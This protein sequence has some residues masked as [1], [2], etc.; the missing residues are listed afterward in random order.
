[1]RSRHAGF[2]VAAV[3]VLVGTSC[4][5][6]GAPQGG[7]PDTTA[8]QVESTL[9]A[10]GDVQVDRLSGLTIQFSEPIDKATFARNW[11]ISPARAG[12]AKIKWTNGGRRVSISW[13]D[14][15]RDS[16]SY[17]VTVSNRVADRHANPLAEP[18]TFAFSTGPQVDRGEIRGR[19][20]AP[21]EGK[22][23]FDVFAYR[24]E[25]L[26][27][28]FWLSPPDY[29]TQSAVDGRFQLPFLRAG[30]YRLLVLGDNNRNRRL[31]HNESFALAPR[32]F[33]VA[34]DAPPDSA[35]FFVT[36][37]DT[38]PFHLRDCAPVGPRL[39]AVGFS[40]PLDTAG[41]STWS[42][43]VVDS[44]DGTA[45]VATMLPP[46]A[47]RPSQILLRGQW[48]DGGV[49]AI[50]VGGM[51]DQR[52]QILADSVCRCVYTL[53]RDSTGPRIEMVVLPEP[54]TALTPRDPIRWVF[55]EP[56]DTTQWHDGVL[57][58]DT[59]GQRLDGLTHWVH[60]Q[61]LQ[62]VPSAP[63]P[64]TLIALVTL[65]S[66]QLIDLNGNPAGPGVFRWRFRPLG[67]S[68]IGEIE[69][70]VMT[71]EAITAPFWLEARAIGD[72][73][74]VRHKM[75]APGSFTLALPAGRWQ[76]GGFVDGNDD[77]RW[78]AG[79]FVPF[80]F[81]EPRALAADTLSVR[82]RFTLE[83]ITLEL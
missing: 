76:L 67:E 65:D 27:D 14:T 50:T 24:L 64:D 9:P 46:T 68:Q 60:E 7:A 51:V 5:Q 35:R 43:G 72:A 4:A 73:R 45:A 34:D 59:L 6:K 37:R 8:P 17:R 80:A 52:G 54:N 12:E 58:A 48:R 79:S 63:W 66:A 29:F 74:R 49:Y 33:A 28:T 81:A 41:M 10:S 15:L 71:A 2:L 82:A 26:P 78:L 83:D 57:V 25:S 53:G 44:V 39:I 16:T 70:R 42:I 61:E 32:D 62:F 56:L 30:R 40:H 55:A 11:E 75:T 18:Y 20:I 21:G 77:G 31:D 19:I 22:S 36:V 13:S 23:T 69:G 47:R 1:M 38:V 3:A